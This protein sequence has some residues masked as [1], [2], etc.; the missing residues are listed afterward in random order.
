[1]K[2]FV[3]PVLTYCGKQYGKEEKGAQDQAVTTLAPHKPLDDDSCFYFNVA[4]WKEGGESCST[5]PPGELRPRKYTLG[6]V[7]WPT[8]GHTDSLHD[9]IE[10]ERRTYKRYQNV[11]ICSKSDLKEL[12]DLNND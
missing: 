3:C 12:Q 11:F 10:D 5:T 2:R 7:L 4:Q 9:Y 8:R 6:P 1:M